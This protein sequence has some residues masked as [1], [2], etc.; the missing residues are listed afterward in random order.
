MKKIALFLLLAAAPFISS[1][2]SDDGGESGG[3]N[4]KATINGQTYLFNTVAVA[5]QEY[6]EGTFTYTDVELLG[7]IDNNPDNTIKIVLMQGETGHDASWYFGHFDELEEFQKDGS[8]ST[9]ISESTNNFV[10]GTFQGTVISTVDGETK[11]ITNGSFE[12]RY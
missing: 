6:T 2:S 7:S 9:V 4:M 12:V 1:C 8:F 3:R 10:K 5:T 11:T